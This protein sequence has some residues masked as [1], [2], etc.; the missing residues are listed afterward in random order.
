MPSN[1]PSP[2]T[3]RL[4]RRFGFT[5]IE[6]LVVIAII[7]ILAAMLLPALAKA[8]AKAHTTSC[9]NQLKQLTICW[10]MYAGDNDDKL[11][12]NYTA[13]TSCGTT[14]WVTSGA[15]PGIAWTGNA[16]TD[17]TN[18]ALVYGK[19]FEYNKSTTIY[20]CPADKSTV[21]V[22][23]KTLR[24]R[25][26]SMS[27]GVN[28]VNEPAGGSLPPV[29][30]STGMLNPTASK[31]SVF[32]DEKEESIDN[33][34]IGIYPKSAGP[35]Y[36]NV[37]AGTRHQNGCVLSFGDGHAEFWKWK[38]SYVLTAVPFSST[39]ATDRDYQR[40]SETVPP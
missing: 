18:L 9:I 22:F 17:N 24:S 34:A 8:K 19:L 21:G 4:S 27:T 40:L 23:T 36:W 7:A 32:L 29:S 14:A 11:V 13:G 15:I 6:L 12:N 35:G 25:S 3:R 20:H 33:N 10:F 30:K 26:Y 16:Q 1:T 28:W 31:A 39:P 5:L 2:S 38:D 37:P